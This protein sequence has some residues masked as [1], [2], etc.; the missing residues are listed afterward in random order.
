LT[1]YGVVAGDYVG[2]T[3]TLPESVYA[4]PRAMGRGPHD[5]RQKGTPDSEPLIRVDKLELLDLSHQ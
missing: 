4:A 5:R 3:V 2:H 1:I